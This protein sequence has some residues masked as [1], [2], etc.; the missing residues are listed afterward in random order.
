M[1]SRTC[2]TA[3]TSVLME[4]PNPF[5]KSDLLFLMEKMKKSVLEVNRIVDVLVWFFFYHNIHRQKMLSHTADRSVSNG[6]Q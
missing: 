6:E 3:A 5:V 4:V 1:H 2:A